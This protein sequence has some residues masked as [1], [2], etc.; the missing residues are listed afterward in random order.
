VDWHSIRDGDLPQ[1]DDDVV[2]LVKHK[3]GQLAH[4]VAW[5][6]G[7]GLFYIT[8]YLGKSTP[9]SCC[10]AWASLD[11]ISDIID[12]LGVNINDYKGW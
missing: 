1:T 3:S 6:D 7:D 4:Y 9:V 5:Y 10:I 12:D 2:V 11:D 8:T